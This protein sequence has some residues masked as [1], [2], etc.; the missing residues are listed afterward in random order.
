MTW[1]ID[2]NR[3][4]GCLN[5]NILHGKVGGIFRFTF[6]NLIDSAQVGLP[7]AALFQAHFYFLGF[8]NLKTK[9]CRGFFGQM[10]NLILL[11]TWLLL[12]CLIF[13]VL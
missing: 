1:K 5:Q 9:H 10:A 2:S 13:F 11:L 12:L 8:S 4:Y 3:S 7:L 6:I